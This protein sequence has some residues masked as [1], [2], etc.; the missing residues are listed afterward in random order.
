MAK[1]SPSA[2]AA[3]IKKELRARGKAAVAESIRRFFKSSARVRFIGVTTP[4]MRKVARGVYNDVKKVW[5][6]EDA[7]A[8]GDMLLCDAHI[9][10]RACGLAVLARFKKLF[11]PSMLPTMRGWIESGRLDNWA[12]VDHICMEVF[13]PLIQSHPAIVKKTSKWASHRSLWM[14]R[15]SVVCLCKAAR[16]GE[17]LD[18][19]YAVAAELLGDSEDLMHKAVGWLLRDAGD[20]DQKRL[21]AFLL[22]HGPAIPRTA[23]RYALEHFPEPARKRLLARTRGDHVRARRR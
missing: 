20:A 22:E 9:E 1:P 17:Y 21:R 2:V 8:L 14:R 6:L 4:D 7:L 15:A 11:A 3:R 10:A 16:K 18:A 12:L 23:V 5:A 13:H 19:A